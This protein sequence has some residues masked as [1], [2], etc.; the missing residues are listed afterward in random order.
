MKAITHKILWLLALSVLIVACRYADDHDP[1]NGEEMQEISFSLDGDESSLRVEGAAPFTINTVD[2]L[3]CDEDGMIIKKVTAVKQ[4]TKYKVKVTKTGKKRIVHFLINYDW[5]QWA[6]I[7]LKGKDSREILP[8]SNTSKTDNPVAWQTKTLNNGFI[9][10]DPLG[11]AP[12]Q[13]LPA[14]AQI[15]VIRGYDSSVLTQDKYSVYNYKYATVAPFN[16]LTRQFDTGVITVP[17]DE[18]LVFGS[19]Q[20]LGTTVYTPER[21]NIEASANYSCVILEGIYNGKKTYYKI[22]IVDDQGNRV[23]LERNKLYTLTI[24]TISSAG[25]STKQEALAGAAAN[26]NFSQDAALEVYPSITDGKHKLEVDKNFIFVTTEGT[27]KFKATYSEKANGGTFQTD[28]SK[29]KE[30]RVLPVAGYEPAII[31]LTKSADGEVNM[32]LKPM[33]DK[34]LRSRVEVYVDH[35]NAAGENVRIYRSVIVVVSKP[36]TQVLP[37]VV[38]QRIQKALITLEGGL[39]SSFPSQL[40]PTDISFTTENFYPHESNPMTL[41]IEGGKP[42]YTYHIPDSY[43]PGSALPLKFHSNK[44]DNAETIQISANQGLYK[45]S[46]N[47]VNN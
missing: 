12:I 34:E 33:S 42:V 4:T 6:G 28:N 39:P 10:T 17:S 13:V 26:T 23:N 18:T 44:S 21:K 45:T 37:N 22:D 47:V 16:T 1:I 40:L 5:A 2:L 9:G 15:R 19:E 7:E 27:A 32:T 46:V 29:I 8:A 31:N 25:A 30:P 20:S 38:A 24:G 3:I 11:T 43:K 35:K 14:M 36:F 41:S